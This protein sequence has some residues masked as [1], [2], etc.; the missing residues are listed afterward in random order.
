MQVG[1][2]HRYFT[3]YLFYFEILFSTVEKDEEKKLRV[4]N[5]DDASSQME[6]FGQSIDTVHFR[7]KVGL[8]PKKN[9]SPKMRKSSPKKRYFFN[10]AKTF[11][12]QNFLLCFFL[13]FGIHTDLF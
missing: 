5:K 7:R 1:F 2:F 11:L 6:D 10:L 9:K 3:F 13:D 4:R 8:P 12:Y